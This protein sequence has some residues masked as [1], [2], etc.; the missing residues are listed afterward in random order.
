MPQLSVTFFAKIAWNFRSFGVDAIGRLLAVRGH[1]VQ[2]SRSRNSLSISIDA[3]VSGL[4]AETF[5]SNAFASASVS[6]RSGA[7]P[8]GQRMC[9]ASP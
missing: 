4:T 6:R 9:S 2:G 7:Q 8:C 5:A 1:A 3:C